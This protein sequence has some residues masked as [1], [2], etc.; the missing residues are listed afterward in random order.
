MLSTHAAITLIAAGKD[1]PVPVCAGPGRDI[2]GR[3]K[4]IIM[5]RFKIDRG[6]ARGL[7]GELR[8]ETAERERESKLREAR[9]PTCPATLAAAGVGSV[10]A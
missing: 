2:I 1:K 6:Q 10:G 9:L 8:V 5:E 7:T 4:G 3:A